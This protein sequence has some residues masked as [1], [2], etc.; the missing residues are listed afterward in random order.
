MAGT[1]LALTVTML[2]AS[3][4]GF[5]GAQ[6][7]PAVAQDDPAHR[8]NRDA[9]VMAEFEERIKAYVSL[10]RELEG[11]LPALPKD[12]TQQQINAHR[13]ALVALIAKTRAKALPGDIFTKETRA[14]FRRYLA[15]VFDGPQGRELR[16]SIMDEN[17]GR[18]RLHI[19]TRYPESVPV[20]SVPPQVLQALPRL[21]GDLEYR[22]IGNRLL[23]HDVRAQIIV[24]FFD[25]AIDA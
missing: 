2:L 18:L 10:R 13:M 17:P 3:P 19:N 9:R 23:L 5:R 16:A 14:L 24:D 12:P 22:F 25:D 11:T 21:P 20:A 8:V 4:A 6:S 7:P 15:R 1:A